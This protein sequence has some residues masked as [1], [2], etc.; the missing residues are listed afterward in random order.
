[1]GGD[2]QTSGDVLEASMAAAA[3]YILP[4]T[5]YLYSHESGLLQQPQ[6]PGW[7]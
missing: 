5:T 3:A 2:I 6:W 7:V 4:T 1:M